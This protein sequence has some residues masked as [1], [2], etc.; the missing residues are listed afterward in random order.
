MGY[1]AKKGMYRTKEDV[2]RFQD[3]GTG[4]GPSTKRWFRAEVTRRAIDSKG[5]VK[6]R[7]KQATSLYA[8][9]AEVVALALRHCPSPDMGD[10]D[11]RTNVYFR[12]LGEE[13]GI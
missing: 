7:N 5:E 9:E 4:Q 10:G 1:P 8:H 2:Y 13:E 11:I 3:P 12:P 6:R